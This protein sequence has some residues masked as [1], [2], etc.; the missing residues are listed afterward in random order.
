MHCKDR[1]LSCQGKIAK[2]NNT[3]RGTQDWVPL[4]LLADILSPIISR[5][6]EILLDGVLEL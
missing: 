1:A 3:F 4:K 2:Q 5:S 6:V